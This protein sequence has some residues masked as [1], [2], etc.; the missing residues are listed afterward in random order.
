[1]STV[2]Q[3]MYEWNAIPWSKAERVV[4]KL[5]KRIYQASSRDDLNTVHKLQRLLMKSWW[6]NLIA[7]RR[8]TQDNQGKKTAGV[9]G[10]KKLNPKQR[11]ELALKIQKEPFTPKAQSVRRVWIPKPGTNEQR[12]LGIP[13]M[14]DRAR[15]ALAKLALEPQWEAQFEPNSYGFRSGRSAHDAIEA[16]HHAIAQKPKYVL[17]ADIAK[18]FDRIEH[19]AVLSKLQTFPRLKQVIKAWLKAGIMEGTQLFPSL[20]G[21]PQGSVISPLLANVALHGLETMVVNRFSRRRNKQLDPNANLAK[22]LVVRYADDFCVFD[23]DVQVVDEIKM[24]V[25]EWLSKIGLELKSSKTRLTHTLERY[26]GNL[27]FN[28]LGFEVRQ[29]RVGIA[30][31]AQDSKGKRLGFKS[32]IKP[33]KQGVKKHFQEMGQLIDCHRSKPQALLIKRLNLKIRGWSNYYATVSSKRRFSALD[34]LLYYPLKAW[35]ERRHSNKGKRWVASKYWH[36]EEGSW[37]FASGS[38]ELLKHGAT[39][40]RRHAKV[41]GNKSPFDGDWIYWSSR[42]G[43]H[44]QITKSIGSLM[45]QQQGKCGWCGLYF[46]DGDKLEQDHRKPLSQGGIKARSNLQLLHRHC[47]DQKS[48]TDEKKIAPEVLKKTAS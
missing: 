35:A 2:T 5:Q 48:A 32:Y 11:L 19:K 16:I 42:M 26:E 43:R 6:A 9:D 10:V 47:H 37:H 34:Y 1:M 25:S 44:P 13:V 22:P 45:K 33:S 46:K 40:I 14:E 18:C 21:C 29:Y 23:E 7:V 3:P 30:R 41:K 12:P 20:E 36:P 38:V 24:A 8:V 39:P 31:S 4:F 17:D 27:G 28:F 15:Q